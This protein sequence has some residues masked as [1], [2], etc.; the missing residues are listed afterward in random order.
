MGAFVMIKNFVDGQNRYR[1][2]HPGYI[3]LTRY[4]GEPWKPMEDAEPVRDVK[5]AERY[6]KNLVCLGFREVVGVHR[7]RLLVS[8]GLPALA[9]RTTVSR[10]N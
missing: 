9:R 10:W 3:T 8:A 4:A 5:T 1:L 2:I 7:E 6:A